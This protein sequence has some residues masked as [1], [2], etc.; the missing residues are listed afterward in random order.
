MLPRLVLNFWTQATCSPQPPKCWDYRH[1]PPSPAWGPFYLSSL[2]PPPPEFKQFSCLRHLSCWDY[3][4]PFTQ[5]DGSWAELL[6]SLQKNDDAVSS[7]N[8][9]HMAERRGGEWLP[10][11]EGQ[12]FQRSQWPEGDVSAS[13][14]GMGTLLQSRCAQRGLGARDILGFNQSWIESA[15][16]AGVVAHTSKPSSLGGRGRWITRSRERDHPDQCGDTPSLLKIQ[17]LAGR[18][19]GRPKW[20]DHMRPG[21]QDQPGQHGETPSLLKIQKLVDCGCLGSE[22]FPNSVLHLA[23]GFSSSSKTFQPCSAEAQ[24][25]SRDFGDLNREGLRRQG[26]PQAAASPEVAPWA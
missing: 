1:E 21:M 7:C 19:F 5:S 16:T 17:R 3:R 14:E 9:G 6:P 24:G 2:Q 23:V 8:V 18:Y 4:R 11:A 20:A 26:P 10:K 25:W 22:Y 13:Q 12:T 15:V